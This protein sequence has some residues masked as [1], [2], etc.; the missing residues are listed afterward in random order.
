MDLKVI[1]DILPSRVFDRLLKI[2]GWYI[3]PAR[4]YGMMILIFILLRSRGDNH[5]K[6]SQAFIYWSRYDG[7]TGSTCPLSCID[8]TE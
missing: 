4:G 6:F 5:W 2:G 7:W 1:D 3:P 8:P